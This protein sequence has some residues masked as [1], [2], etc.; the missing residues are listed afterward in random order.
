M[1]EETLAA[2]SPVRLRAWREGLAAE[3][4]ALAGRLS[5][6]REVD[7]LAEY[8]RPLCLSLALMVTGIARP[9]AEELKESAHKVSAS[10]AEPYDEDLKRAA[11]QAQSDL[12]SHFPSGPEGLRDSGFVAL[13]ETMP[14]L[15]ANGWFALLKHPKEWGLLHRFPELMEQGIEE[16]FR[17]SGLARTLFRTA[18][19]DVVVGDVVIRQGELVVLRVIAGNRDPNQFEGANQFDVMRRGGRHFT[20]GAGSHSCAGASLIRMAA[21]AISD[22]LVR[23][24]GNAKLVAPVEWRGGSG[25]RTPTALRVRLSE[26]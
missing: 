16:L 12:E 15:L 4:S 2:L 22:P 9:E 20:L 3:A 11:K 6:E 7:L 21:V 10:A 19:T 18:M 1:R 24:F 25:F 8:A 13:V 5:V 26:E 23:K 17:Y 14:S